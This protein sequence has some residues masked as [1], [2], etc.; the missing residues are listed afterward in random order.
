MNGLGKVGGYGA[1]SS[2]IL[3][4]SF[5]LETGIVT[6]NSHQSR[7]VKFSFSRWMVRKGNLGSQRILGRLWRGGSSRS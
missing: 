2:L 5:G 6:G 3:F 1:I 4:L 7:K